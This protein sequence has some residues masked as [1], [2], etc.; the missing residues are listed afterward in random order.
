MNHVK[1]HSKQPTLSIIVCRRGLALG[2]V[3]SNCL[4]PC[5]R[6]DR[7][8]NFH[9]PILSCFWKMISLSDPNPVLVE[10]ILFV[11]E[12][13]P[14]VYCDAQHIFLC[15]VYFASWGKITLELFCLQ[16]NT[17]G[18]SSHMTSLECMSCLLEHD[19]CNSSVL[20][21]DDGCHGFIAGKQLAT[22]C[23]H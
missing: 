2:Q 15:F 12:N 11:S 1:N 8:V 10:I 16:L 20:C 18:W 23:L 19:I 9:Y 14:K 17:I 22:S 13:Y 7:I 6:N 4:R 3:F 21:M 5:T